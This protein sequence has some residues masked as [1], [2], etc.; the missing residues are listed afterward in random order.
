MPNRDHDDT[1][2]NRSEGRFES[3]R[4]DRDDD[5]NPYQREQSYRSSRDWD[6]RDD[7][8][9]GSPYRPQGEGYNPARDDNDY[10]GGSRFEDRSRFG[11]GYDTR[12]WDDDAR[13]RERLRGSSDYERDDDFAAGPQGPYNRG[14]SFGSQGNYGQR[15]F[16]AQ[17]PQGGY[18]QSSYTQG[19]Y[20]QGNFGR[21]NYGHFGS[22]SAFSG[23]S[24]PSTWG[25]Q[26]DWNRDYTRDW[27]RDYRGDWN[28]GMNA[29]SQDEGDFGDQ[30]RHAGRSFVGKVKRAFRGPKGYKRSDE[31]IRED[32]N[33]RLAQQDEIDPSDIEVRVENGDVTLTGSVRTRHEK[34]RAEEIADDISGVNDV[35]N[36][37][38]IGSAQTQQQTGTTTTTATSTPIARNGRA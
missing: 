36:Q 38:R 8:R 9:A 2:Y 1:P 22:R 28:R 19:G 37:L 6:R 25:G 23:Q 33:D 27:D 20:P 5:R 14:R 17:Y 24:E 29:R 26:S 21:D 15:G 18:P 35:H 34:F 31:R 7:F 13:W 3:Q 11:R 16:G 32:V 30:L 10:R 12:S 4:N